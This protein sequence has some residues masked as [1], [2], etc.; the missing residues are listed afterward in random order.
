MSYIDTKEKR[1]RIQQALLNA[2]YDIGPDSV[3]GDIGDDTKRAILKFRADHGLENKPGIVEVDTDLMREL[4]LL[5]I[6]DQA[7]VGVAAA[8]GIDLLTLI[9]L[10]GP[11][12]RLLKGDTTVTTDQI[13]G[14]L[15]L[16]LGLIAGY[17]VTKGIGDQSL[18]DWITAGVLTA[19]P[20]VWSWYSN[21]PKTILSIADK[22]ALK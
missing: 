13:T 14:I 11:V 8:K 18:W 21:R 16:I 7:V 9:G 15:R 19:V 2:H 20:A 4:G 5:T 17:F 12:L 6:Q 3:D 22:A 1:E 10:V